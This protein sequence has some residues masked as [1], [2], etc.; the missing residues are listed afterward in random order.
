MFLRLRSVGGVKI[1]VIVFA[2]WPGPALAADGSLG[3]AGAGLAAACVLALI[4]CGAAVQY[5]NRLLRSHREIERLEG[6]IGAGPDQFLYKD[7]QEERTSPGLAAMVGVPAV[8]FDDLPAQF[9]DGD[10]LRRVLSERAPF[11]VKLRTRD[12]RTLRVAGNQ[13]G[14]ATVLWV[15]NATDEAET[16]DRL[17]AERDGLR[18]LLD[19]VP[20]PVWRRGRDLMPAF[21][22]RAYRD[23]VGQDEIAADGRALAARVLQSGTPAREVRH[24]VIGG[25]RRLVEIAEAPDPVN[26]GTA[27]YLLDRTALEAVQAELAR[28]IEGHDEVLHNL[29]TAIAIYSA[30]RRLKFFN[31]AFRQMWDLDEAWLRTEPEMGEVLE[32]LRERRKLP[33]VADFPAFKREEQRK[34]ISLIE[35]LE[36]LLHLPDDKTYRMTATPHP[37]GGLLFTWE[38]VTDALA[39]ERNYNTLIEVQRETLDNLG[40]GVAVIGGDGRLK[41]SNPAFGRMWSIPADVLRAGPHIDELLDQA[42]PFYASDAEWEARKDELEA[43][44]AEREARTGRLERVDGSVLDFASVPLPDGAVLLVYLD[45]SD[46]TRVERALRERNEA[47]ETADRLKSE[48]IANVSYELRTPL[49]TIIGFAEILTDQYFGTLNPRQIEYSRGILESSQRLLSLINDI[50]DLASIE[51]GHMM[52]ELE[53]VD[54]YRMLSS[55]LALTRERARKKKLDIEFDCPP[56]IGAIV[57]DERRLKQALFNILSNSIKFTPEN[58]SITLTVRRADGQVELT[59]T[60]TGIGIPKEDHGRVFGKFERGSHPEARHGAGLGLSLVKSFIELHGGDLSLDSNEG[61]GTRLVC[62]LPA[63]APAPSAAAPMAHR[64]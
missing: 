31:N 5:R 51:A 18:T 30:D 40:E 57:A 26:G 12:R 41:L 17:R 22:N 56:D 64:A 34:F 48:F 54:L 62:R 44:I 7:D 3:V 4:G 13:V 35:P 32:N 28:H 8:T 9:V 15:R 43:L 11:N 50:L 45:V 53:T 14:A 39:L 6:L 25:E 21:V 49:N 33:E 10:A 37:F 60:D 46:S 19:L 52:L 42:R 59:F 16:E 27:G 29:G 24:V 47:L 61:A 1:G 63:R 23:A 55:V 2:A 38:D 58:G 20:V 36:D